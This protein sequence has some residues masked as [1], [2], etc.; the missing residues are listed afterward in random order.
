M[1][2]RKRRPG[3]RTSDPAEVDFVRQLLIHDLGVLEN[4]LHV[5]GCELEPG[6][7]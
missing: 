7:A 6:D 4:R 1:E 2:G 5:L 3:K